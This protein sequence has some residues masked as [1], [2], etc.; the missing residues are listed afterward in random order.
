MKIIDILIQTSEMLC[1]SEEIELLK[2]ATEENEAEVI[3]NKEVNALINLFK[4]S[5][6]ELCTNYM[7]IATC[8]DFQTVSK[9]YE[10]SNLPNYIRVQSVSKNGV[11][12]SYKILNRAIVVEEDGVYTVQYSTYPNINS[13]FEEIDYLTD[14]NPDVLVFGLTSYYTLS[15]GRFDEF[16]IFYEHYKEKAESLKEMKCFSMPQ[17]RWE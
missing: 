10:L 17:R 16:E 2:S 4:Y 13:I 8:V 15:R 1:L 11:P 3:Q 6:Q 14:F 5:I 9:K 12:V 7:P